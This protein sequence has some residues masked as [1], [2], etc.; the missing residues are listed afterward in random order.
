ME[1]PEKANVANKNK[2]I[3]LKTEDKQFKIEFINEINN[4]RI[5]AKSLNDMVPENFSNKFTLQDIKK[6]KFFN[7]DYESIDECLSEIFDRLDKNETKIQLEKDELNITV[8]LYS[9]KYPEIK[10]NLKKI[11]KS[12]GVKYNELYEIVKKLKEEHESEVKTLKDKINYLEELLNI[13]KSGTIKNDDFKGSIVSIKCFGSDEFDNYFDTNL[14]KE[15]YLIMSFALSCK[16]EKD[17]HLALASFMGSKKE[18]YSSKSDSI[19]CRI[20]GNKLFI[21]LF[22]EQNNEDLEDMI[23][24]WQEYKIMNLFLGLRQKLTIKINALPN[25]FSE[26]FDERKIQKIILDTELEFENMSPQ[27]QLFAYQF[28]E[29]TKEIYGLK[30]GFAKYL[31]TD[32][33]MNVMNGKYKYKIP[34][35]LINLFKQENEDNTVTI[36][37][38]RGFKDL[39]ESFPTSFEIEKFKDYKIIDFD[40]IDFYLLSHIHKVGICFNFKIPR[41][42]EYF[43]EIILKNQAK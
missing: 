42:N 20:K 18:I 11:E 39:F 26:E 1:T 22:N 30:S 43:D 33:F 13:K 37:I 27:I 34:E 2:S 41:L 7:D 23:Y 21:D 12:E 36:E 10:F 15:K 4:L 19:N 17:I 14:P 31:F 24:M 5:D 40:N 32:I 3:S 29:M 38:F 6:V 28:E 25:I 35:Y 9:K 8:P 16:N